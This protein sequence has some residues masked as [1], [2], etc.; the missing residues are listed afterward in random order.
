MFVA[1]LPLDPVERSLRLVAVVPGG[2][3]LL[4]RFPNLR[5]Q[6]GDV[7]FEA[8]YLLPVAGN[9]R[10]QRVDRSAEDRPAFGL[11]GQ[12]RADPMQIL[13]QPAAGAVDF[14]DLFF[15]P[16]STLPGVG[17]FGCLAV[18]LGAKL[19]QVDPESGEQRIDVIERRLPLRLLGIE[20]LL[21]QRPVF[22]AFAG[23]PRL[24]LN[25]VQPV[26]GGGEFLFEPRDLIGCCWPARRSAFVHRS[27]ILSAVGS[28]RRVVSQPILHS[29]PPTGGRPRPGAGAPG[30][31][32]RARRSSR[33]GGRSTPR[34]RSRTAP[35]VWRVGPANGLAVPAR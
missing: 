15:E 26:S 18:V 35:P 4:V 31:R 14:L 27:G 29:Q 20:T 16:G 25:Q 11:S 24:G 17:V 28:T 21:S 5:R 23:R 7:T 2:V 13:R 8:G 34:E 32:A 6:A 9:A 22:G 12:F 10:F 33:A 19:I 1:Q 3:D 30:L